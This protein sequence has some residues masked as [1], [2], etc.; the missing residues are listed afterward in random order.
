M[1]CTA[2]ASVGGLCDHVISRGNAH[3]EVFHKPEDYVSF[4]RLLQ[5]TANLVRMRPQCR[6]AARG[7][8][9]E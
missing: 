3:G 2:R 8:L 1:P 9:G 4:A 6:Y 5:D 7:Y